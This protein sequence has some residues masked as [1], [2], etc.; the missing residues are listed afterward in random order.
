[1]TNTPRELPGISRRELLKVAG[2][3]GA[4]MVVA[5]SAVEAAGARSQG[6]IDTSPGDHVLEFD[7][8]GVRIGSATLRGTEAMAAWWNTTST[9]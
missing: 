4:G 2:V 3:G 6:K 7:L 5:G 8:P 1:M 9:P